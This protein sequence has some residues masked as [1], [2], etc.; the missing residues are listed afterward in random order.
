VSV[1]TGETGQLV[2]LFSAETSCSGGTGLEQ[3]LLRVLVDGNEMSPSAADDA[4][5]DN[6]GFAAVT[7][8]G[9]GHVQ[10]ASGSAAQHA[11][12]RY[13]ATLSAGA[14]TVTVQTRTTDDSVDFRV[15]DWGLVVQ[16]VKLS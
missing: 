15:D 6:N 1:P 11:I 7:A 10:N 4:F 12:V 8:P 13:S 9:S 3:C 14:H 5:F 16:R 2:A